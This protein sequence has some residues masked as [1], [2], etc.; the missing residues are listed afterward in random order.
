MLLTL[1]LIILGASIVVFFSD[2]FAG[3]IKSLFEIFWI[4]LL[5]PI[6]IASMLLEYYHGWA[7]WLAIRL[8]E[9]ALAAVYYLNY[10]LPTFLQGTGIGQVVFLFLI[11]FVPLWIMH[12]LARRKLAPMSM[13]PAYLTSMLLWIIFAL[14][15]I[16]P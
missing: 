10:F 13:E 12:I 5:V 11:A 14:L 7:L 1:A 9:Y 6:F 4:R 15:L 2:E 8:K 3:V 16:S